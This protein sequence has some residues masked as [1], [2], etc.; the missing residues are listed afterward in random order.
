M[1]NYLDLC[2]AS[3]NPFE[4]DTI[5]VVDPNTVLSTAILAQS[6]QPVARRHPQIIQFGHLMQIKQFAPGGAP[7]LGGKRPR[8]PGSPIVE[9]VARQ[10][11]SECLYHAGILLYYRKSTIF[12]RTPYGP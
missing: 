2:G 6:L 3:A 1:L 12:D 7:K 5:P 8:G 4:A 10:I 9:Q 11:V